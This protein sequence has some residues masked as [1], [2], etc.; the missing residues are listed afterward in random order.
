MML[1]S[2]V[3][4]HIIVRG[5]SLK[6]PIRDFH[7]GFMQRATSWSPGLE[8]NRYSLDDWGK[9]IFWEFAICNIHHVAFMH[10]EI[11]KA[12]APC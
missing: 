8:P 11:Q 3:Y 6:K 2:F 7:V 12:R 9:E 4:M 5:T 1:A 10:R